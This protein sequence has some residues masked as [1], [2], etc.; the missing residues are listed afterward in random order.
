[1]TTDVKDARLRELAVHCRNLWS[2]WSTMSPGLGSV[3]PEESPAAK[4]AAAFARDHP[5]ATPNLGWASGQLGSRFVAGMGAHVMTLAALIDQRELRLSQWSVIRAELEMGGRAAWL[6]GTDKDGSWPSSDGRVAR[7]LMELLADGRRHLRAAE[8]RKDS[9]AR[10]AFRDGIV[11]VQKDLD[12]V[13]PGWELE[14]VPENPNLPNWELGG[15]R[16]VGLS[17]G[18][19]LFADLS[20]GGAAGLYDVFSTIA[21][22]SW[23]SLESLTLNEDVDGVTHSAYVLRLD[24]LSELARLACLSFYWAGH[25]V[26]DYFRIDKSPLEVWAN[27]AP[28]AWFAAPA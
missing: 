11:G 28:E 1:M 2:A 3:A 18:V 22:P 23:I 9:G 14:G 6:I 10:K 4:Y 13:F 24:D 12:A 17:A 27:S 7:V 5:Y 26:A 16:H 19:K 21:H 25:L 15:E 20:F 8:A